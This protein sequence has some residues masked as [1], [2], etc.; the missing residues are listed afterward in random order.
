MIGKSNFIM[1]MSLVLLACEQEPIEVNDPFLLS[2]YSS[3][4]SHYV[5][6]PFEKS[7]IVF[8][9][10]QESFNENYQVTYSISVSAS[11]EFYYSGV[12]NVYGSFIAKGEVAGDGTNSCPLNQ[13]YDL[14]LSYT[15]SNTSTTYR[16]AYKCD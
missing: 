6:F 8:V 10:R 3:L 12:E 4:E 16:G 9:D 2:Y 1:F 14:N 13:L 7:E 15:K 11:T 5:I